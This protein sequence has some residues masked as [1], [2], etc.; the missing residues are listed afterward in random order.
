MSDTVVVP[1]IVVNAGEQC[2]PPVPRISSPPPPSATGT[3]GR[4]HGRDDP[5]FRLM[6][7]EAA[8]IGW[9]GEAAGS[10]R[11]GGGLDRAASGEP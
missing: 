7:R 6:R 3:H 5:V 1:G 9:Q 10:E 8:C 2:Q 4:L 11:L